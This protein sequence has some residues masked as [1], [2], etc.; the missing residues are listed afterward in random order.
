M[1]RSGVGY[2]VVESVS[3]LLK[4][5]GIGERSIS[6]DRLDG[7]LISGDMQWFKRGSQWAPYDVTERLEN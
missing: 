1:S 3:Q 4:V 6:A 2:L 7:H 5:S